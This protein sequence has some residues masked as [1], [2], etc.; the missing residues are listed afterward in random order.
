MS[1]SKEYWIESN[2]DAYCEKVDGLDED[3]VHVIE[4]AAYEAIETKL[5][6]T[7]KAYE[8]LLNTYLI[9]RNA[10]AEEKKDL[11]RRLALDTYNL[12]D[13]VKHCGDVILSAVSKMRRED[14][15]I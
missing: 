11:I 3:A 4:M 12:E 10:H 14:D 8:E 9:M 1:N 15:G 2:G 7:V 6:N 5:A 13:V